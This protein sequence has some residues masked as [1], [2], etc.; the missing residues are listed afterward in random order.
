MDK[1]K[2]ATKEQL[3]TACADL[4][5]SAVGPCGMQHLIVPYVRPMCFA[6]VLPHVCLNRVPNISDLC[7]RCDFGKFTRRFTGYKKV[8]LMPH[9]AFNGYN[10]ML[11][12]HAH[13]IC[14]LAGGRC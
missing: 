10:I 1:P 9:F 13:R 6:Y 14:R 7:H 2:E 11:S 5:C 3:D 8:Q 12:R 4:D